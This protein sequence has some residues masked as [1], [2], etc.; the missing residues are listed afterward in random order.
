MAVVAAGYSGL[1]LLDV[2]KVALTELW[3]SSRF[4][5][6]TPELLA[7]GEQQNRD[8]ESI[9]DYLYQSGFGMLFIGAALEDAVYGSD[10]EGYWGASAVGALEDLDESYSGTVQ[11][12]VMN[13]SHPIIINT[14]NTKSHIIMLIQNTLSITTC[15]WAIQTDIDSIVVSINAE[16]FK[17]QTRNCCESF[18]NIYWSSLFSINNKF[19]KVH[20]NYIYMNIIFN[21]TNCIGAVSMS[22]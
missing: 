22:F 19:S 1:S 17:F 9:T 10:Q 18:A 21:T 15:C 3:G 13:Q 14:T 8:P 16:N 7:P 5:T 2:S 11:V 6:Y 20:T 12:G 4:L